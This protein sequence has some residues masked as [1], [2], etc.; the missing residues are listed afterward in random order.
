MN[1]P[2]ENA[3]VAIHTCELEG[4]MAPWELV[5]WFNIRSWQ[6]RSIHP[7]TSLSTQSCKRNMALALSRQAQIRT[8]TF[9]EEG[10]YRWGLKMRLI[11]EAWSFSQ[12]RSSSPCSMLNFLLLGLMGGGPVRWLVRAD[13]TGMV[14]ILGSPL[15]AASPT[16]EEW[17]S[18]QAGEMS[19]PQPLAPRARPLAK[20]LPVESFWQHDTLAAILRTRSERKVSCQAWDILH[21]RGYFILFFSTI[22]APP[23]LILTYSIM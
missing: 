3:G 23:R 4:K 11:L 22:T 17:C 12:S 1:I 20:L 18:H 13:A 10:T 2:G 21:K 6:M 9:Q 8:P 14:C 15:R 7:F 19:P 5:T 16:Q